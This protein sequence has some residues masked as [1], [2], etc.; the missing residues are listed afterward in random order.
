MCTLTFGTKLVCSTYEVVCIFIYI[1]HEAFVYT[2][3]YVHGRR[4]VY[5]LFITID[6]VLSSVYSPN[7]FRSFVSVSKWTR[8]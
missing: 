3:A 4:I 7:L 2:R 6:I 5:G 8:I 1:M